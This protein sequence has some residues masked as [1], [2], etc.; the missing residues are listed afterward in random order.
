MP[1]RASTDELTKP[2]RYLLVGKFGEFSSSFHPNHPL[3]E[4]HP[5][6]SLRLER[7]AGVN[8]DLG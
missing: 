3:V 6:A 8:E 4:D 5:D 7:E 2:I 1:S